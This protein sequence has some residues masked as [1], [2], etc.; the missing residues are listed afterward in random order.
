MWISI[1]KSGGQRSEQALASFGLQARVG[2][3]LV[4]V[5]RLVQWR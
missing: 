1:R 5:V 4:S 3:F 2:S